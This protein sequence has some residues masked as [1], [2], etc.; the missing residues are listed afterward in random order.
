[1][2]VLGSLPYHLVIVALEVELVVHFNGL[3]V[4]LIA[5]AREIASVVTYVATPWFSC[6]CSL[7]MQTRGMCYEFIFVLSNPQDGRLLNCTVCEEG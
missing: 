3:S 5:G 4:E 6:Q 7:R 2:S 1:M